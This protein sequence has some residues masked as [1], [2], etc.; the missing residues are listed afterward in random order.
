MCKGEV[1]VLRAFYFLIKTATLQGNLSLNCLIHI[2]SFS[3]F[4]TR[5]LFLSAQ[6][7]AD[8]LLHHVRCSLLR[9][10]RLRHV[11][12]LLVQAASQRARGGLGSAPAH[13]H[14]PDQLFASRVP[15]GAAPRCHGHR[16]LPRLCGNC[17]TLLFL[18]A[19]DSSEE[20]EKCPIELS[21][22]SIVLLS[23]NFIILLG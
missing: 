4:K 18:L 10:R 22:T 14:S 12:V 5:L 6:A 13:E 16:L 3:C 21:V 19:W 2:F 8:Q 20:R 11:H 1:A 7:L 15:H 23:G 9:V 17:H